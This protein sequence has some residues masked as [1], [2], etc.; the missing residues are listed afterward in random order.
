MNTASLSNDARFAIRLEMLKKRR[1]ARLSSSVASL[2]AP[3]LA[4]PSARMS[5]T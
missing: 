2:P 1:A 3:A 4:K 5:N